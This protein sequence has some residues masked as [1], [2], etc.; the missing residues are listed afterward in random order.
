MM[1]SSKKQFSCRTFLLTG[2]TGALGTEVFKTLIQTTE[3]KLYLLVRRRQRSSH[4]DRIRKLLQSWGCESQ[5]GIR[6]HALEGDVSQSN[7]GLK[8]YE[9]ES[10]KSEVTHFYHIAA[11]TA[12]NGS[13]EDCYRINFGGTKH[14]LDI[15]WQLRNLGKL[16]RFFYFS[17]AYVAG[18]LH[19]YVSLE[20]GL[21]EDPAHANYYESSKYNAEKK[22]RGAMLEGLP[23]TIFRPSIVVGD[24]KTGAVSEFNVIYP[25]MKLFASGMMGKLPADPKNAF[26]I[27][28]IDFIVNA[29]LA[30]SKKS[31]SVG[32]TYH[33]VSEKPLRIGMFLKMKDKEFPQ[34]PHI[35]LINPEMFTVESLSPMEQFIYTMMQPYLGYLTGHLSFDTT[36][37]RAALEGTGIKQPVTDYDFMKILTQYAVDQGYLV[38][39]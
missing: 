39:P 36:N 22:V 21:P 30:I 27:V 2:V 25:F 35:E 1:P 18:S 26:N 5:L 20:D 38:A 10:L 33:L 11:L 23:T 31:D 9:I 14:A 12:L 28:P 24:S 4:W 16:E 37:T 19:D 17:T 8:D 29:T 6:V 32:K 34:F 15:A 7:F 13:E 3:D